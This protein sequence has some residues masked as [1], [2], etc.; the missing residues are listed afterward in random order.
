[1]EKGLLNNV[2]DKYSVCDAFDQTLQCSAAELLKCGPNTFSLMKNIITT[3]KSNIK[4]C[5][6]MTDT[7][8][9]IENDE[10]SEEESE[11]EEE[12]QEEEASTTVTVTTEAPTTTIA[13]TTT[14]RKSKV[15]KDRR[16]PREFVEKAE[17][18]TYLIGFRKIREIFGLKTDF[19]L[20]NFEVCY[21]STI[22]FKNYL[23]TLLFTD[24]Q[25]KR[26][27]RSLQVLS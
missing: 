13:P 11:E 2:F 6:N 16:C 24:N 14:T 17:S 7:L 26:V 8:D 27:L 23:L 9:R 3:L 1:M 15:K 21:C 22:F 20:A 4:E 10:E 12:T 19:V 18:C 25:H 5:V